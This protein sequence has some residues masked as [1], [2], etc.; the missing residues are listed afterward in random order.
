MLNLSPETEGKESSLLEIVSFY[1]CIFGVACIFRERNSCYQTCGRK[2]HQLGKSHIDMILAT[3]RN[4]F[5]AI[6]GETQ[7]QKTAGDPQLI[8]GSRQVETYYHDLTSS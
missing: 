3:M 8:N 4:E 5:E 6:T 7:K 1:D 2:R